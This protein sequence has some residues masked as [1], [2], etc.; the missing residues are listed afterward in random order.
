MFLKTVSDII[1]FR[2]LC[3]VKSVNLALTHLLLLSVYHDVVLNSV[4][5]NS[6]N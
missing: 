4:M 1:P 5:V 6:R 2:N 3:L